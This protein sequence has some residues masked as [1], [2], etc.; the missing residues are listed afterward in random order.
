M[1]LVKK[2]FAIY[3]TGQQLKTDQWSAGMP[4]TSSKLHI[5]S[6]EESLKNNKPFLKSIV[7]CKTAN[8]RKF[9]IQHAKKSQL[10]ILQSLL[11]AFT[12][13]DISISKHL[14][15]RLKQSKKQNFVVRHFSKLNSQKDL[16]SNLLKIANILPWFLRVIVKSK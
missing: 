6:L 10:R 4:G 9:L 11:A 13:G 8:Q 14:E 3:K 2:K 1:K 12:R 16:L 5:L 7:K 15:T